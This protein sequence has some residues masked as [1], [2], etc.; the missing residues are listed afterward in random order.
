MS[1]PFSWPKHDD[2][3][4][5][6]IRVATDKPATVETPEGFKRDQE[7]EREVVFVRNVEKPSTDR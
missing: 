6:V 1:I 3:D 2:N 4:I 7:S 5:A